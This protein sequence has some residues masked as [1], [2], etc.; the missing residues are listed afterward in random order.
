M[1]I[2]DHSSLKWLCNLYNP[3]GRQGSLNYV[4]DA[5]I[6]HVWRR[7]RCWASVNRDR[8]WDHRCK[9]CVTLLLLFEFSN[10]FDTISHLR[11]LERLRLV[12]FSRTALQWISS[13]ISGRQQCIC[14]QS[15]GLS[16]E[17]SSDQFWDPCCF[18]YTLMTY[19]TYLTRDASSTYYMQMTCKFTFKFQKTV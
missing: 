17:F 7:D 18:V 13:Y 8:R 15:Q 2:T 3:T 6:S 14:T 5:L 19:V 10:A 4:P 12:G 11:L 9:K 1:V 16:W